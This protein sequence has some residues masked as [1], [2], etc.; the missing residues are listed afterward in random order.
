MHSVLHIFEYNMKQAILAILIGLSILTLGGSLAM[1]DAPQGLTYLTIGVGGRVSGMGEAGVAMVD[2]PSAAYWNPAGL[3]VSDHS[4]A[5]FAYHNWL[6]DVSGQFAAGNYRWGSSALAL[7][8]LGLNVNDI[9]HRISPTAE[10]IGTFGS[11]D[12]AIGA[13]YARDFGGGLRI[14]ATFK[15]LWESIYVETSNGWAI[16]FGIQQDGVIPGLALGAT[17]KDLGDMSALRNEAP[18]LPSRI[19]VGAAYALTQ[20]SQP[21]IMIAADAEKPFEGD[22]KGHF[23]LEVRPVKPLALRGG[24]IAGIETRSF[25]AGFGVDWAQFH[26]DYAYAPFKEDLGDG[27]RF[28][29][30]MDF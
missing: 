9:E 22:L 14:G 12:L 30:G 18:S 15:Y 27:H 25:T 7:D 19:R 29:I 16:D 13:S 11:H 4:A 20:I 24:Y 10:P 5:V 17:L 8:Y 23:G 3:A 28:S 6:Q 21:Q 26:V 2:D 1:A